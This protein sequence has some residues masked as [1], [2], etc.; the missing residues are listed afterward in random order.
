MQIGISLMEYFTIA[1][2]VTGAL[3]VVA[4]AKKKKIESR[5]TRP[6]WVSFG[7][8][9]FGVLALVLVGR[10]AIADWE[11]VP[12]GSMEPNLRVNDRILVNK[13]AYGPRLPFTNAAIKLGEP[14]RGD[15]VVFRFPGD[16]STLFVKRA[17]GLPGDVVSYHNGNVS[18]NHQPFQLQPDL[19]V[20]AKPEDE[21][22]SFFE[23]TA[24]GNK[25]VIKLDSD[26]PGYRVEPKS[27]LTEYRDMCTVYSRQDWEC[28]VP[29]HHYLMMGDNRDNSADSRDWGFLDEREIYGKAVR[30]I[31]NFSDPS[32]FW[33]PL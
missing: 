16:V 23:E 26:E 30:V 20:Q 13:L 25:H 31:V 9:L 2:L 24:G 14:H 21:G 8:D 33:L 7:A 28:K 29:A 6:I 15:I 11:V 27:W 5:S 32:R 12:S 19:A 1:T 3:W 4:K 22:Q 18:I 17:I 10:V